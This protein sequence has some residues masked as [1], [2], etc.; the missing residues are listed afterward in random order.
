MKE[1]LFYLYVVINMIL[2]TILESFRTVISRDAMEAVNWGEL[3]SF[4]TNKHPPL[5]GWLAGGVY[6]LFGHNDIAIYLLGQLC[7]AIGLIFIYRLSKNFLDEDKAI[8]STMI[9][10]PCFYYSFHP[11]YDNF[12]C[13]I[14]SMLLWP[15]MIYYFY[16]AIKENKIKDWSIVGF[17]AGLSVLAKYQ[18]VFVFLPMFLYILFFARESFKKLGVYLAVIFA[19][20]IIIPHIIH[21][22]NNDFFSFCYLMERTES[23]VEPNSGFHLFDRIM[24]PTKFW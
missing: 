13:N 23:T 7:V 18:V 10:T 19:T 22:Y 14:I 20:I 1:K 8:C 6:N 3:L 2:W 24:F 15:I 9:L 16:N 21:L 4:G 5:S 11:F 12:N 17:T